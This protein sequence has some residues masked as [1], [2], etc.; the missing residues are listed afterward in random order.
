MCHRHLPAAS[1]FRHLSPARPLP[2]DTACSFIIVSGTAA[3]PLQPHEA[4]AAGLGASSSSPKGLDTVTVALEARGRS[5]PAL[6]GKRGAAGERGAACSPALP[7]AGWAPRESPRNTVPTG[8]AP[9]SHPAL[10]VAA[11]AA[12]EQRAPKPDLLPVVL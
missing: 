9:G 8:R 5:A 2:R 11:E 10:G 3:A 6:E 4:K 1:F 12:E 7:G